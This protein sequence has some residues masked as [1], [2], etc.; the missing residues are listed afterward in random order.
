MLF[1]KFFG[2]FVMDKQVVLNAYIDFLDKKVLDTENALKSIYKGVDTAPTPS[3]SHSDTTRS[4]QSRVALETATRLSSLKTTRASMT[5][6]QLKKSIV[7]EIGALIIVED[8]AFKDREYYFVVPDGG[9]ESIEFEETEV[10]FVS[11][12]API[13][14]AVSKVKIRSSFEFRGR[15]LSL[16]AIS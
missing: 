14:E 5:V 16:I 10:L 7:P 11:I 3:E 12:Q 15:K 9:G 2:R 8:T 13:L 1:D 4:Q 6:M